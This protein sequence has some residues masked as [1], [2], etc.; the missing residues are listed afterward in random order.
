MTKK[1]PANMKFEKLNN[2]LLSFIRSIPAK[3]FIIPIMENITGKKLLESYLLESKL[4]VIIGRKTVKTRMNFF[5]ILV[6]KANHLPI[7]FFIFTLY[8]YYV[9]YILLLYRKSVQSNILM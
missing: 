9:K 7:T 3:L 6:N 1:N 8:T 5:N 4:S 2:F